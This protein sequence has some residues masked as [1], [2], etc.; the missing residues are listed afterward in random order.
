[1]VQ[2]CPDP[3]VHAATLLQRARSGSPRSTRVRTAR[4]ARVHPQGR[5]EAHHRPQ[6]ISGLVEVLRALSPIG[7][8]DDFPIDSDATLPPLKPV[9]L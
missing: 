9:D 3:D 7:I 1:M 5:D 4:H 6:T 2:P 8:K